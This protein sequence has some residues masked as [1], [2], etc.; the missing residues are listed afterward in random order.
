MQGRRRPLHPA[1]AP[2]NPQSDLPVGTATSLCAQNAPIKETIEDH[3]TSTTQLA[4]PAM[5]LTSAVS[6]VG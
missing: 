5:V 1:K 4:S 3:T 2:G 6:R